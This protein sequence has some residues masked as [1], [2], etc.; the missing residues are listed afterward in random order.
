[1]RASPT[2]QRFLIL[3]IA[4][5]AIGVIGLASS[6]NAFAARFDQPIGQVSNL[7]DSNLSMSYKAASRNVLAPGEVLTYTI[8]LHNSGTGDAVASVNDPVPGAMTL[9]PDSIAGGGVYDAGTNA[10]AWH[11]VTVTTGS[12]VSL[13]FAVTATMNVTMPM[14]VTNTA[15]ISTANQLLDRSATVTLM[16]PPPPQSSLYPS[17]KSASEHV[18]LSGEAVTYTIKLINVGAISATANVSDPVPTAMDYVPGSATGGGAYDPG[19]RTLTWSNVT[20]PANGH[21][22][23]SFVTTATVVTSPTFVINTATITSDNV[24]F[25]RSVPVVIVPHL[26]PLPHPNLAGSYKMAS[27]RLLAPDDVLT[28]TIRLINSGND[29]ALVDV[30]DPVPTPMSYVT[31]SANEGGVYDPGTK[32]LTWNAITVPAASNVSLSFAVTSTVNVTRPMPVMNTATISVT[33]DGSFRRSAFV[34][35]L[36]VPPN[37]DV[38]PPVVHSLT[39]DDQDVL[40]NPTVTLHIS[41][42]DNVGVQWMNLHEWELTTRPLPHW[43]MVRS[44]GWITYQPEFQ[45]TLLPD[46]GTHFMGVWVAD[47]AHNVSHTDRRAIDFASLLLPN[48]TVPLHR[49]VPYLVY[50]DAGVNVTATLTPTSGDADLYVWYPH[51][52]FWPDQRSTSPVTMTDVVT[53]TTPRAGVY[54]FIVYGHTAATYDLSIE[55]GGGPR[56][57]LSP[58]ATPDANTPIVYAPTPKPDELLLEPVL[59]QSGVD[60]LADPSAPT[61]FYDIY[62]PIAVR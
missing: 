21:V 44:T 22:A 43:S 29:D 23:L 37:T 34:L 52:F 10:I 8:H 7:P 4:L 33:G 6:H 50:Y 25:Q 49:V 30:T 19:T 45:W 61:G 62:L 15:T 3:L 17:Y 36:P 13:S 55:P 53:F 1:M 56:V 57:G 46:S 47:A 12:D 26:V 35:L 16:P 18:L 48:E 38:I 58:D 11:A 32:I 31:G 54:L 59:S 2:S 5:I 27:Q 14:H 39:I 20:V 42:T 24:T 40:T 41:A 60:P 9:I 51:S 28:Y